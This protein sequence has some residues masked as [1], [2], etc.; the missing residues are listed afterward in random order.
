MCDEL[1]VEWVICMP[2]ASLDGVVARISFPRT[3]GRVVCLGQVIRLDGRRREIDIALD[4]LPS[5]R[6]RDDNV[7]NGRFSVAGWH[8][9]GSVGVEKKCKKRVDSVASMGTISVCDEDRWK[10]PV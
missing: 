5:I 10:E 7:P 6:L 1:V 3:I 8:D 4:L 2:T 9:G